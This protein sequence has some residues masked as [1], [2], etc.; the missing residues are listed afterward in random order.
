MRVFRFSLEE[1]KPGVSEAERI[2]G[3]LVMSPSERLI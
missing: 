1:V 3:L 2:G